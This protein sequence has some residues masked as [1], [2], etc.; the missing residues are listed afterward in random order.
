MLINRGRENMKT[1]MLGLTQTEYET[2]I[3]GQSDNHFLTMT[4]RQT[5]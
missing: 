1:E 2:K 3:F 4:S 5:N